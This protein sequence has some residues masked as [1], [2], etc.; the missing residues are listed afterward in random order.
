MNTESMLRDAESR[1]PR[2]ILNSILIVTAVLLILFMLKLGGAVA[3]PALFLIFLAILIIPIFNGLKR[4]LPPG[5]ALVVM[6]AGIA[7]VMFGLLWL[8]SSSFAT[9][10]QQLADY[11][12]NFQANT[13][14]L[15]ARLT[16]MGV[17]PLVLD[18]I[19]ETLFGALASVALSLVSNIVSLI[20]GSILMLIALAF[21][22]LESDAF[23]R[24]LHRGLGE[25][26]DLLH[27]MQLFQR[28]LFGYVIAQVKLNFLT[29]LGVFVR[30]ILFGVD[31]AVLWSV[32]AFLLS[33]IPYIGLIVAAIPPLLLG[34]AESGLTTVVLL[35]IGYFVINQVIEQVIEP[36]IVGKQM[37]LSPT[38]TLF[39]VL[40]WAWIL[41]PLGAM[42]A[43]PLAALMILVLGGFDDTRW[44]AILFSSEDSP[45]VSGAIRA[46]ESDPSAS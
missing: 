36:R 28:S 44:L 27:R 34:A 35:G 18:Q 24:R 31:H 20:T 21:I 3:G 30:L 16:G 39:S 2:T 38:L 29:G 13:Q 46:P 25:H 4:R 15:T 11:D 23:S 10:A 6:L 32:L 9:L 17:D 42:L 12:L 37:T 40:F 19:R 8:V 45:L 43:G 5:L 26:N 22:L 14:S 41:G 7:G 33:F 1:S